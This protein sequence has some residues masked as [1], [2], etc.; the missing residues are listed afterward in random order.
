MGADQQ[1]TQAAWQI[2]K[3]KVK[4]LSSRQSHPELREQKAS[5]S[6]HRGQQ[7]C[8]PVWGI[9]N[10]DLNSWLYLSQHPFRDEEK[11]LESMERLL[12]LNINL[13][14]VIMSYHGIL[15]TALRG[16]IINSILQ[17]KQV[18]FRQLW[19]SLMGYETG[20]VTSQATRLCLVSDRL[21]QTFTKATTPRGR[22]QRLS[23]GRK[24]KDP[25]GCGWDRS[26]CW[27][28]QQAS[29][30]RMFYMCAGVAPQN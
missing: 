3:L 24:C 23:L 25:V 21:L 1:W 9:S 7:D 12:V 10:L 17:M 29:L 26:Y 18:R 8:C 2:Q 13:G 4:L 27:T 28:S 30:C 5:T 6:S 16:Q 15:R 20:I 14:V 11:I 19:L 22:A